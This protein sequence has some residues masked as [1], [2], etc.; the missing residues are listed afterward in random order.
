M[1]IKYETKNKELLTI[2]ASRSVIA[3]IKSFT[4]PRKVFGSLTS[5]IVH[6]IHSFGYTFMQSRAHNKCLGFPPY[7]ICDVITNLL[8]TTKTTTTKYSKNSRNLLSSTVRA[9]AIEGSRPRI[10]LASL[11]IISDLILQF[12]RY[13][14]LE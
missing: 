7:G 14:I 1:Y 5:I 11:I 6:I 3:E 9:L 13:F 12:G 2:A 10:F 8:P 4:L